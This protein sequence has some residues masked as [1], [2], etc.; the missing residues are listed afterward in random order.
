MSVEEA[1]SVTV[2]FAEKDYALPPRSIADITAILDQQ[3]PD[4]SYRAAVKARFDEQPP[5]GA[6]VNQ[7]A[8][9]Y[10]GRSRFALQLGMGTQAISDARQAVRYAREANDPTALR[11]YVD[12]RNA[13]ILVGESSDE[14]TR[15]LYVRSQRLPVGNM[16]GMAPL[17]EFTNPYEL[18]IGHLAEAERWVRVAIE[19]ARAN[20]LLGPNIGPASFSHPRFSSAD[21]VVGNRVNVLTQVLIREGKLTD[22][23]VIARESLLY[24][25]R[26]SGRTSPQ[27]AKSIGT[28]AL[29]LFNQG[30]N[31]EAALLDEATIA[32]RD[33]LGIQ[34]WDARNKLADVRAMQYQWTTAVQ[35][36]AGAQRDDPRGESLPY[37]SFA[38][39]MSAY[40]SGDVQG[41]T[42]LANR[43]AA[44]HL[45]MLGDQSY[46][47]ALA[48][49]M[50]ACGLAI[51]GERS[52]ALASFREV[53]P[54]LRSAAADTNANKIAV[55]ERYRSYVLEAY[56][57]TLVITRPPNPH[58]TESE[59]AEAFQ[60][61]DA[62]RLAVTDR[63]VAVSAARGNAGNAELTEIA[64]DEQDAQQQ[65]SARLNMLANALSLPV[66]QQDAVALSV[67]RREIEQLRQARAV[68]SQE[69]DKRYPAYASLVSPPPATPEEART[70]LTADEAL[71]ALYAGDKESYAWSLRKD[72]ATAFAVIPLGRDQLTEMVGQLRGA[73]NPN[74]ATLGEIPAFDVAIAYRLYAALLEPVQAGWKGASTL[75]IVPHG[76]LGQIPF[77]ML[78]TKP[79][80]QPRDRTELFSGYR[81]VPFLVR[82]VAVTQVPSV[83]TLTILRGMRPANQTRRAFVGFGDPWFNTSQAAEARAKSVAEVRSFHLRAA[84]N[85]ESL[86]SANLTMLP[87]LPDT[88]AEV[89][90]VAASL[91]ANPETDVFLGASANERQVRTM[92]LDD[93]RIIMFATHGLLPGDLDGLTQPALALSAPDVAGID[94]DGLLTM[95]KILSLKLDADWV[96]LSAC[97]TA[98]G[99]GAGADAISGLGRAFFYAGA[100]ALLVTHWPVETTSARQITT[101]T[102]SRQAAKST[103]TRAQALRASM[104]SLLDGPGHIDPQTGKTIYSFAHPIFWAPFSLVGDG[105]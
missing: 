55:T 46:D 14:V 35:L 57:R 5:A 75:V 50:T 103:L 41:G 65:L 8:E 39:I 49:G 90:E 61:A 48:L 70:A 86:P 79:T 12:L 68:L 82:E 28:L 72:G 63:A 80:P 11:P 53:F 98:A 30:R 85:T 31:D 19:Y 87:R 52:A 23:E 1:K 104:M 74:A 69:I 78:V 24:N 34:T 25:L 33:A 18:A 29:V 56:L 67:L 6:N 58:P 13:L 91:Q 88:A 94:G 20:T 76:P 97:N 89:R 64:R 32:T 2:A 26:R 4:D 59:I 10:A 44:R 102:F 84:P 21:W 81:D 7:L 51:N 16:W 100:R 62:I 36:Y 45:G 95:D 17:N 60:V 9:F 22:A 73:L 96:V 92:K 71:I 93:R 42:G 40:E 38:R 43:L 27:T 83:A 101:Q 99:A 66:E 37:L 3:K 47:T 54:K 105:R 15:E 77:S